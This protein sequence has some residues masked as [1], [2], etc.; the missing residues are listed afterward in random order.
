MTTRGWRAYALST[1]H[2]AGCA[3]AIAGPV[4]ALTGVVPARVGLAL[5]VPFT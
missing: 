5:V 1:K 3:L 2:I 4:L